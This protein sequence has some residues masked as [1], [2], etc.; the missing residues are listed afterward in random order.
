MKTYY[1]DIV[2]RESEDTGLTSVTYSIDG[3]SEVVVDFTATS[4]YQAS[5][6]GADPS[7]IDMTALTSY[8]TS[9]VRCS[10]CADGTSAVNTVA[11]T[12]EVLLTEQGDITE[13]NWIVTAE[14][15]LE[16]IYV[17]SFTRVLSTSTANT[18]VSDPAGADDSANGCMLITLITLSNNPKHKPLIT[19]P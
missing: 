10:T 11:V 4:V 9:S 7:T 18:A 12:A 16:H 13:F 8:A 15:G 17:M 14:S 6:D 5:L 3:G 2:F 19:H 1:V